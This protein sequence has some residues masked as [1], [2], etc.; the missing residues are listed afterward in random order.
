VYPVQRSGGT[1]RS[2]KT[3]VVGRAEYKSETRD[4]LST[5][6]VLLRW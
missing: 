1:K 2:A 5:T 4:T 6:F 3:T